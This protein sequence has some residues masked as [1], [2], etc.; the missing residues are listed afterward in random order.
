[1]KMPR[2]KL[3]DENA[4]IPR[5]KPRTRV[6]APNTEE[7][8]IFSSSSNNAKKKI[9]IGQSHGITGQRKFAREIKN[10]TGARCQDAIIGRRQFGFEEPTNLGQLAANFQKL[11]VTKSALY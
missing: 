7:P 5:A 3:T 2:K 4:D 11:Q 9:L 6:N 10:I 1:M 8:D